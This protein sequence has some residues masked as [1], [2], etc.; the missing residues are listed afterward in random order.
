MDQNIQDNIGQEKAGSKVDRDDKDRVL[1]DRNIKVAALLSSL[2]TEEMRQILER[3]VF[4]IIDPEKQ[5]QEAEKEKISRTLEEIVQ[6]RTMER[7]CDALDDPD[8]KRFYELLEDDKTT[9]AEAL[10]KEKGIHLDEMYLAEAM[11]LKVELGSD[12][13]FLAKKEA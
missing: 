13:S 3:D 7:L 11:F 2:S 5:L 4:E 9:E 8:Q 6:I 1:N 10:L 12:K